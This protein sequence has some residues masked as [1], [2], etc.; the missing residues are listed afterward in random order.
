MGRILEFKN[1][2]IRESKSARSG[3]PFLNSRILEFSDSS[4]HSALPLTLI[5]IPR[6][7]SVLNREQNP[8]IPESRNPRSRRRLPILEFSNSSPSLRPSAHTH[9]H[10]E[11]GQRPQQGTESWNSRIQESKKPETPP[12]SRIL[13]FSDSSPSLRPPAHTHQ[14]TEARQR[15]QHGPESWNSRIQESKKPETPPHS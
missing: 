12:H 6:Q 7:A 2:R 14:H 9:Q 4:P 13:E 8:G 5:N 11:A 10:T 15:A 1:S 3:S